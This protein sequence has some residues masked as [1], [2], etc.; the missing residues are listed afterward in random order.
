[1]DAYFERF[2]GLV[3][4]AEADLP[5]AAYRQLMDDIHRV[6]VDKGAKPCPLPDD[7]QSA[8]NSSNGVYRP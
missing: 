1:V 2:L 7:V 4:A 6:S 5:P 3:E 8:L